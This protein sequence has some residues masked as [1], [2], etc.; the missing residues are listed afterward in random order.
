MSLIHTCRL[1]RINPY[2]YLLAIAKHPDQ[3]RAQPTQ[4]FPWNYPTD[5]V[6]SS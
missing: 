1:N 5:R 4:W 2:D 6:D 3:V